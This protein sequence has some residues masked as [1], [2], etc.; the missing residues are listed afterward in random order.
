MTGLV[1]WRRTNGW[2]E[3]FRRE[4]DSM[5]DRFFAPSEEARSREFWSPQIDVEE[6]EKEIVVKADVPG[7]D[8]KDLDITVRDGALILRGE[9]KEER[10]EKKKDYHFTERWVG[11]FYREIPLPSIAD[12]DKI[13]AESSKGV[14]TIT[15]PKKA[16]AQAKKIAVKASD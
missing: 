16:E 12:T 13:S 3:Q 4:M 8:P 2:L 5:F 9:K 7:V 1:P 11:K 10:E 15:I 14:V 6:S